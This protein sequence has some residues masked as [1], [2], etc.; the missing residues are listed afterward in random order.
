M[1]YN[2]IGSAKTRALRVIWML[3]E[4][5][6]PYDH[7]PALPRSDEVTQVNVSGKVPVLIAD[8]ATLTDS[9]AILTYLA[10]RHGQFTH[11]AGTLERARQD[12]F[13]GLILDEI[14][15]VLWTASRHSFIL[16]AEMRLPEIKTSLKW[17]YARNLARLAGQFGGPFLMGERMTV[18]DILLAHCLT[19]AVSAKFPE[20]MPVMA[21]FHSR[22]LARPAYL[23]AIAR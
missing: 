16:P 6:Q 3:E 20:A 21:E 15:G 10:D 1:S 2:V 17:E 23:R 4:L 18:P 13:T 12:G 19:W 7:K 8:G 14:D 22:M 11:P 5:G 9:T